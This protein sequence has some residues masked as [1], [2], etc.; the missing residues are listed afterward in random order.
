VAE[1]ILVTREHV[2]DD[3]E[4]TVSSAITTE[5]V[6]EV[7]NIPMSSVRG[8]IKAG[9]E[10]SNEFKAY[11]SGEFHQGVKAFQN[12]LKTFRKSIEE[13][14]KKNNDFIKNEFNQN[15]KSFQQSIEAF[16]QSI[17]EQVK[18]NQRFIK[19]FYG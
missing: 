5:E 1:A 2:E 18:E 8:I 13:Q 15:V 3:V 4:R 7:K 16:K 19:Q 10:K 11:Y 12:A 14:V 9:E 17:R 6:L